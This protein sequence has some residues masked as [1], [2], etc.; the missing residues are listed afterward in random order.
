M[1]STLSDKVVIKQSE[2]QKQLQ[3]TQEKKTAET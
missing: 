1:N 3:K 2:K